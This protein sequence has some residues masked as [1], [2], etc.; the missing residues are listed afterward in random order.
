M[1]P[2]AVHTKW[3]RMEAS[4]NI[5]EIKYKLWEYDYIIHSTR[6]ESDFELM[7]LN[8]AQWRHSALWMKSRYC[9]IANPCMVRHKV[10]TS[11]I[12]SQHGNCRWP[13]QSTLKTCMDI[14]EF[15]SVNMSIYFIYNHKG[16]LIKRPYWI[17]QVVMLAYFSHLPV[18]NMSS[19]R[20]V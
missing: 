17:I 2:L 4:D 6:T 20:G 19:I 5:S 8:D 10:L 15:C 11:K 12:H 9:K 13:H 3:K 18:S 14:T 7:L 1:N 16:R